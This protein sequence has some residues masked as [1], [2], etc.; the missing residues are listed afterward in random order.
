MN[1]AGEQ[2]RRGQHTVARFLFHRLG[3]TREHVL[4]NGRR[5][6]RNDAVHR[7]HLPGMDDDCVACA[8]RADGCFNFHAVDEQPDV[9]HLPAEE[10]DNTAFRAIFRFGDQVEIQQPQHAAETGRH[11]KAAGECCCNREGQ[12]G[13]IIKFSLLNKEPI[14]LRKDFTEGVGAKGDA[15][16]IKEGRN[17][18]T[19]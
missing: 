18:R 3:L 15:R 4:I 6:G 14:R 10:I 13:A 8:D 2:H 16:Q 5:A 9:A 17:Q 11:H 19:G 12:H 7:D 1:E